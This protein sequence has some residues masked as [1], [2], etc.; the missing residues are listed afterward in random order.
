MSDTLEISG[1]RLTL[2]GALRPIL[3]GVDLV[4]RAGETVALV[5]ESGSGKTLTSRAALGMFP[6]GAVAEGSVRVD[7]AEVLGMDAK[8]LRGLRGSKAAM[9]FQDPRAA[10]NPLRRIGDFLSEGLRTNGGFSK[11]QAAERA[12]V[13]LDTVGLSEAVLHQYPHELSGG[14]LQRV[15]IAAALTAD[16][17]LLLADEPTTALDVTTQAEIVALL[18]DLQQRFGTALL[19]VTHDL[20]LAAAIADRVCVMYA[21]RIV[22]TG[23]SASVFAEPRHPYTAALLASTPRLDQPTTR[24]AAI[25]GQV[26]DPRT[27]IVGCS[28]AA[29]CAHA[30]E[31]CGEERPETRPVEGVEGASVACLISESLMLQGGS[32]DA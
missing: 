24:L 23:T 29:R 11:R 27:P 19:F 7:G 3:D 30:V 18:A 13:V 12:L 32:T 2:P 26:P 25:P 9:V 16:P 10:V 5:G 22:E 4:V 14:M 21:G 28:F 31:V 6:P 17:V 8:G 15:V 1:L 20:E